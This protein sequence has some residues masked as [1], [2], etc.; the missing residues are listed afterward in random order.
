MTTDFLSG[1][2]GLGPKGCVNSP[3]ELTDQSLSLRND[4]S[5]GRIVFFFVRSFVCTAPIV[6][7]IGFDGCPD[8]LAASVGVFVKTTVFRPGL[9]Y[10]VTSTSRSPSNRPRDD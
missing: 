3:S 1:V 6:K 4:S 9:M 8:S 10:W 7:C 5:A 2:F